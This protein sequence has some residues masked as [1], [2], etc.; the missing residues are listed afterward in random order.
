MVKTA[1]AAG[2]LLRPDA[3][4][5]VPRSRSVGQSWL[6]TPFTTV[7]ALLASIGLVFRERPD[8]ILCNGPGACACMCFICIYMRVSVYFSYINRIIKP[9]NFNTPSPKKGTCLPLCLAGYA[10]RFLGVKRVKVVFVESFCRVQ[11]LS[12]TGRLLYY[13]A[14]RFVVQWPG[15]VERCVLSKMSVLSVRAYF[16]Q[17]LTIVCVRAFLTPDTPTQVPLG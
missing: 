17:V 12:L 1:T 10:L 14:D 8:L 4:L 7:Y 6:T 5:T 9:Q 16:V 3:T 11:S 15:L 13:L 2:A